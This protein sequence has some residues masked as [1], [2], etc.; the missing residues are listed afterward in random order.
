VKTVHVVVEGQ[1]EEG[2]VNEVLGPHF[3]AR[4]IYLAPRLIQTARRSNGRKFAGGLTLWS[5]AQDDVRRYLRDTSVAAVTTLFDYYGLPEGTPGLESRPAT[6]DPWVRVAHVEAAMS[7]SFDHP[8]FIPHLMLHEF[9]A[10]IYVRPSE[11]APYVDLPASAAT[12]AGQ[13]DGIRDTC[14]GAERIN[15]T[16]ITSPS[17]RLLALW[18]RYDKVLHGVAITQSVGL[19]ALRA[20]CPHF[21]SWVG[22]LES[23]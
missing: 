6:A 11:V 3:L 12:I 1:T 4:D 23:L 20:G 8:R 15:E 9:E 19:A 5:H 18:P 14:G 16:R 17:H 21:H 7:A 22:R 10:Y 2:F 13:L